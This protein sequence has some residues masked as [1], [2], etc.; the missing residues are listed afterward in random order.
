[1]AVPARRDGA[2]RLLL[3]FTACEAGEHLGDEEIAEQRVVGHR[4]VL[5]RVPKRVGGGDRRGDVPYS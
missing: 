3:A 2:D 4:V 5:Q 1:M